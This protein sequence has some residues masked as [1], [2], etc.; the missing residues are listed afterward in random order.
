MPLYAKYFTGKKAPYIKGEPLDVARYLIGQDPTL[1]SSSRF[2]PRQA[3]AATGDTMTG[4]DLKTR[5]YA[6]LETYVPNMEDIPIGTFTQVMCLDTYQL[7][8][9][10]L[11]KVYN[12]KDRPRNLIRVQVRIEPE[13]GSVNVGP[14][15]EILYLLANTSRDRIATH[16]LAH[17][18][19][20]YNKEPY[21]WGP[22]YVYCKA[23][24]DGTL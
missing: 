16:L 23:L 24:A 8:R 2:D 6:Y 12:K 19:T 20:L 3:L 18:H 21:K 7:V 9:V 11:E 1:Y 10:G 4:K 14:M 22:A 13:Q 17:Y 15:S 5:L